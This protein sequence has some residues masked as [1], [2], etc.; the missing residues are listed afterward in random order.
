MVLK[1]HLTMRRFFAVILCCFLA[2][3]CSTTNTMG[4]REGS[5]EQGKFKSLSDEEALAMVA[6][7]YNVAPETEKDGIA[8][9]IALA[10]YIKELKKRRSKYIEAS[11]IYELG[12]VDVDIRKWSDTEIVEYY[13][14]LSSRVKEYEAVKSLELTDRWKAEVSMYVTARNAVFQEGKRRDHVRQFVEIAGT[15]LVA[16][17]NAAIAAI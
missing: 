7:I 15:V 10:E 17:L 12:Y 11:G 2:A 6:E 3:G 14:Y 9:N 13:T 16:A 5:G 4:F 1:Y 8:K